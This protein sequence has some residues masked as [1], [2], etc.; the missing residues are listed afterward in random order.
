MSP[1]PCD[2][3]WEVFLSHFPAGWQEQARQ[4]GAVERLRGF[5]TIDDLM[6]TLL[7]HVAQGYSLR[8]TV[9]RAKAA[10]LGGVSDVDC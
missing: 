1:A 5:A 10:G 7:L 3:N 9:L 2:E 4:L 6:R 8:E